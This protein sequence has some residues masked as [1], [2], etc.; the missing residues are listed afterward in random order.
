M[1]SEIENILF[2]DRCEVIQLYPSQRYVF[3]IMKNGSS[4]FYENIDSKKWKVITKDDL[5]CIN[6]PVTVFLRD[7]KSRFISGVNTY[8]QHILRDNSDLDTKTILWFV[9]QHLFLNIHYCPQFFWLLNLFRFLNKNVELEIKSID[10]LKNYTDLVS[11][12]DVNTMSEEVFNTIKDFNWTKLELYFYLDQL[13]IE[14]VNEKVKWHQI[15]SKITSNRI[16][17]EFVFSKSISLV[18]QIRCGAQ[19]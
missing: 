1:F 5:R 12:A 19:E 18:D 15:L 4:S 3:P 2:P 14:F 13:L 8:V 17:N 11:D 6:S 10:E 7:P 16:L 9:N